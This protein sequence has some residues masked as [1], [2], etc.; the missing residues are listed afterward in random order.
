MFSTGTRKGVRNTMV[1]QLKRTFSLL[2]VGAVMVSLMALSAEAAEVTVQQIVPCQYD[3]VWG[4]SEG[5]CGVRIGDEKNGKWGYVDR[6]GKLVIPC[7]YNKVWDFSEGFATVRNNTGKCGVID[8]AGT[9]VIPCQYDS[10]SSFYEG[11]AVIENNNM[12]GVIDKTGKIVVPLGKY[13]WLLR[14]SEGLMPVQNNN[15]VGY[16]DSTGK[17]V[18]PCDG[19]YRGTGGIFSE[20]LARVY[21][22]D[23]KVG[24]IDKTG[25][26][27]V[28]CQYDGGENFTNGVVKVH[29][30]SSS[31]VG[32]IKYG[33]ID[34]TGREVIPCQYN[35]LS[36]SD[37]LAVVRVGS[38]ETGKYGV[39]DQTGKEIVS[40]GTYDYIEKFSDGFAVVRLGNAQ[41]GKCGFIDKTGKLVIPCQYTR[42]IGFS[43]GL[44][45]VAN[46]KFEWGYIDSTGREVVPFRYEWGEPFSNGLAKVEGSSGKYGYVDKTGKEVVPCQYETA[47]YFSDGIAVVSNSSD[48]YGCLAIVD[49]APPSQPE[50]RPTS[51]VGGFN[52]VLETDYFSDSVGWAVEK[53]ITAG[54]SETTFS[55]NATCTTA[56]ILTF[57]WRS[58]GQPEPT[59]KSQFT[60][61]KEGD[62]FYKAALWANEKG[63]VSG[64]LF[65][66]NTPCTRAMVM[67]YLWKLAGS[68][69]APAASF[70]DVPGNSEYAPAVAYAVSE[71]ITAGT[72]ETTFSPNQ[73]CTRGQIV[74]F[75]YRAFK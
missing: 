64:S 20:G 30:G 44:A 15:G 10:I 27:V 52:D 8:R 28:P 67:T 63:L 21:N 56:Q 11:F 72:S 51:T 34:K 36:F 1:K 70:A 35:E 2:L 60:D 46:S 37:G 39:I 26:E 25:K 65:G 73:T 7:Q 61:V 69:S 59:I 47:G 54:T 50:P 62:Y 71:K 40:L 4:F 55:P 68:P 12:Q 13:F 17:E 6:T 23:M 57:L 22:R 48:K 75:L 14:F 45:M 5:L 18:I 9:M 41:T 16:I 66:G 33:L 58:Q 24:Y 31:D 19:R 42:A 43:E 32:G 38:Y 3:S 49:T 74:T 53:G 29:T